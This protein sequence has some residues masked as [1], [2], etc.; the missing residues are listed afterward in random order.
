MNGIEALRYFMDNK[1]E[2]VNTNSLQL[3]NDLKPSDV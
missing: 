3:L 2:F 1:W